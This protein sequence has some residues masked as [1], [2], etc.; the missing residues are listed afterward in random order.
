M[1]YGIKRWMK[2]MPGASQA[3]PAHVAAKRGDVFFLEQLVKSAGPEVLQTKNK[4][5]RTA[6]DVLKDVTTPA[7]DVALGKEVALSVISTAQ[8][9]VKS[10]AATTGGKGVVAGSAGS[11]HPSEQ[12]RV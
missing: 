8:A 4:Y 7:H 1:M 9:E 12:I 10:N 2:D 3:T 5:G 11:I 6:I